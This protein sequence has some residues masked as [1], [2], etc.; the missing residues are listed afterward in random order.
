VA[1]DVAA[2]VMGLGRAAAIRH[3]SLPL[4]ERSHGRTWLVRRVLAGTRPRAVHGAAAMSMRF[5]AEIVGG[6][7]LGAGLVDLP[8]PGQRATPRGAAP[9]LPR[10]GL[11]GRFGR[12]GISISI[13]SAS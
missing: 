1:G 7:D 10:P 2:G 11:S 13:T 5:V 9:C 4:A 8:Q 6:F 3:Q 12:G